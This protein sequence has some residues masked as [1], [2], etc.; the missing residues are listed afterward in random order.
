MDYQ[1]Q[2]E[3]YA[4]HVADAHIIGIAL[5]QGQDYSEIHHQSQKSQIR[6]QKSNLP[7]GVQVVHRCVEC[8]LVSCP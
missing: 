3:V 6:R 1:G 4:K 5:G 2:A 8:V 7:E